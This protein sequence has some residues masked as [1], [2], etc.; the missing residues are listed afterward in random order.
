MQVYWLSLASETV[1]GSLEGEQP[2]EHF[3][4][5]MAMADMNND[6]LDDLIVGAPHHSDFNSSEFRYEIGA[7]YVFH[8]QASSSP[9]G[10]FVRHG[11]DYL[12]L[13]GQ[14]SGGR[15]GF[16]VATSVDFNAD[17]YND[18]AV[19]APYDSESGTVFIYLGSKDGLRVLPS[20]VISGRS[21]NVATF[22]FSLTVADFDA[23]QYGDLIVG[24]YQ[25]DSV[26]YLPGRPVIRVA[27]ELYFSPAAIIVE[28]NKNCTLLAA[29]ESAE[30][31]KVAC[32]EITSCS[33]YTGV[34]APD[35]IQLQINITAIDGDVS[36]SRDQQKRILFLDTNDTQTSRQVHLKANKWQCW[37]TTYFINPEVQD[38][39]V[40][41][42]RAEMSIRL[43]DTTAKVFPHLVP[44]L[45]SDSLV[46]TAKNNLTISGVEVKQ[47]SLSTLEWWIYLLC[48]L[49]AVT[50]MAVI[51][52]VL[53]KVNFC[54]QSCVIF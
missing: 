33:S 11:S 3:G 29:A 1:L 23:N 21:F 39:F 38:R 43:V 27:S 37:G 46:I 34:G 14:S 49:G 53:Y 36:D 2:G 12:V 47:V 4:A 18:L 44:I 16:S 41:S 48:V 8:Q 28:K 32:A 52:G 5:S 45:D 51:T 6:G 25:S 54:T 19:G 50:V 35:T 20:Q 30:S 7:V 42:V 40:S 24:A 13:K 10:R 15:F 17:G 22:G 9:E 26:I 31:T